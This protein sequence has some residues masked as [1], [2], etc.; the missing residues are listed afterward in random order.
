MKKEGIVIKIEGESAYVNIKPAHKGGCGSCGKCK[1][2]GKEFVIPMDL[3]IFPIEEGDRVLVEMSDSSVY[4]V[5][6]FLYLVPPVFMIIGY[7]LAQALGAGEGVG[8]AVSF[9]F[10]ILAFYFMRSID[11]SKGEKIIKSRMKIIKRL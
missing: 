5:G 1:G 2:E 8:V 6:L 9:I 3:P 4:S 10:L 11:R 7:L